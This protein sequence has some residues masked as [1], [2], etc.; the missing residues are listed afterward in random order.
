MPKAIRVREDNITMIVEYAKKLYFNLDYL[1]D[2][3]EYAA[4]FGEN[5]YL[6][7]DGT[8]ED[9]NITFTT[10]QET[11]FR[12]LWKFTQHEN[13]NQFVKIERV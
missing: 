7:T 10:F 5:L 3:M 9:D 4:E 13:P 2:N 6:I 11:D 1:K 12:R 8:S